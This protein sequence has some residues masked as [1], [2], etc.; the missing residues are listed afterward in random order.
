[1]RFIP[2]DTINGTVDIAGS[3]LNAWVS[4]DTLIADA[5]KVQP[6]GTNAFRIYAYADLSFCFAPDAVTVN[7]G[8]A[9]MILKTGSY[10]V[11]YDALQMRS[12]RLFDNGFVAACQFYRA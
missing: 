2:D 7:P 3:G 5:G 1:M 11:L 9:P 6:A 10:L 12:M 8:I 4:L